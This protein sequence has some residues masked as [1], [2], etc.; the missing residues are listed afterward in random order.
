MTCRISVQI[1]WKNDKQKDTKNNLGWFFK[2]SV[3][4]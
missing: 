3:T 1:L 4:G 2:E